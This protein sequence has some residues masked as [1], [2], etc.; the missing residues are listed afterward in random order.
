MYGALGVTGTGGAYYFMQHPDEFENFLSTAGPAMATTMLAGRAA[1][2]G[3][4]LGLR[5]SQLFDPLVPRVAGALNR[6]AP[7]NALAR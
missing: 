1:R 4:G 7:E 2:L 3:P 6:P 5:G